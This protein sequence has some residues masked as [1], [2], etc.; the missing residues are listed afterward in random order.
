MKNYIYGLKYRRFIAVKAA[1]TWNSS[2]VF[3]KVVLKEFK[4]LANGLGVSIGLLTEADRNIS[5]NL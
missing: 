5:N 2:T 4:C 1:E 3:D